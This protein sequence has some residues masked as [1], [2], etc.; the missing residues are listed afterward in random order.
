MLSLQ[1]LNE[2]KCSRPHILYKLCLFL[3]QVSHVKYFSV[4]QNERECELLHKR[5]PA[6]N[7]KPQ[8]HRVVLTNI[9][10][11]EI[12]VVSEFVGVATTRA[13]LIQSLVQIQHKTKVTSSKL[14]AYTYQSTTYN[15]FKL[16]NW[17]Y[18]Y[19]NHC[20]HCWSCC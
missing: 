12:G 5:R 1:L 13:L 6:S 8:Q 4:V 18:P 15:G 9:A 7:I 20:C 11:L 19:I 10:L 3:C 2:S 16:T 14:S 17:V